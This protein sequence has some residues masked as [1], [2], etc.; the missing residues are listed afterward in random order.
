MIKLAKIFKSIIKEQKSKR[1]IKT[2]N[3][4]II[5]SEEPDTD[6]TPIEYTITDP[7]G[8]VSTK[9]IY[10]SGKRNAKNLMNYWNHL[11]AL[12]KVAAGKTP[13]KYELVTEVMQHIVR[14]ESDKG[15]TPVDNWKATHAMFLEDMGFKNDG[16]FHYALKKPEMRLSYKKGEGFILEDRMKKEKHIF[17]K[18]KNLEEYFANYKQKWER[19]PY[20]E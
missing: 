15:L 11:S 8:N 20:N 14:D 19:A 6:L 2:A 5:Y 7:S 18:F 4:S 1:L 17:P 16:M 9:T 10:I 12:T 13:W 3:G